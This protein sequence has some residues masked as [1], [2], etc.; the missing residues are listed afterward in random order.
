MVSAWWCI[1]T[2]GRHSA[3]AVTED[4]YLLHQAEKEKLFQAFE[5]SEP[6]P[7]DTPPPTRPHLL[8]LLKTVP[9]TGVQAPKHTSLWRP[10][11]FRPSHKGN[12]SSSWSLASTI[13]E[14][15]LLTCVLPHLVYL[16][17]RLE[18]RPTSPTPG[19]VLLLICI[20]TRFCISY[21]LKMTFILGNFWGK[22]S[23]LKE[24]AGQWWHTPLIP[25]LGRQRQADFWVQGQPGLQSEFQDSQ[26]YADKTCLEKKQK[27]RNQ[28][29]MKRI[30]NCAKW[31]LYTF[32]D[33][34]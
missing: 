19:Y 6:T 3:R 24:W 5:T 16:V 10:F 33:Y 17:L 12:M 34:K 13:Q 31:E 20:A 27:K 18:P 29:R 32:H 11:S 8:M 22:T 14:L 7:S 26:G 23:I 9:S 4:L 21:K 2:T 1:L 15:G 28:K 30:H 25:A